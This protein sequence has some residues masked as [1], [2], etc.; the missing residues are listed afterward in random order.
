M[1][2]FQ[3]LRWICDKTKP[4]VIGV[5]DRVF[6]IEI[7]CGNVA[8][9]FGWIY[10]HAIQEEFQLIYGD[11]SYINRILRPFELGPLAVKSFVV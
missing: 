3:R 10:A 7:P 5:Y 11:V 8:K 6:S 1:F 2:K 4:P 9:P